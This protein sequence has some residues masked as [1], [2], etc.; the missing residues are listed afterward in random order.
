MRNSAVI[1]IQKQSVDGLERLSTDL[2]GLIT[3]TELVREWSGPFRIRQN[4]NSDFFSVSPASGMFWPGEAVTFRV[5]LH[6]EKL[7][8][9][10]LYSGAFL[11]ST[12]EGW[13][14]PVTVR[15]DFRG[16][17][18]RLAVARC[19]VIYG[20]VSPQNE[21]GECEIEFQLKKPGAYYLFGFT[22]QMPWAVHLTPEGETRFQRA[23][24][25][26]ILGPERP[27]WCAMSTAMY[28]SRNHMPMKLDAGTHRFRIT[29]RA[30]FYYQLE[31]VALAERPE[32]LLNSPYSR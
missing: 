24:F 30:N 8:E 9:A 18:G 14:R 23:G 16:E 26:G 6:P 27:L 13:S 1:S 12:P 11:I 17:P 20:K 3:H 31:A 21:K 32:Q 5:T 19:G 25:Y 28:S 22:S 10:K 4:R 29:R 2:Y 15:A 7:P